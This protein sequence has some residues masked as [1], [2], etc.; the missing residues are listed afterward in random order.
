M[1]LFFK[2]INALLSGQLTEEDE[3]AVDEELAAILSEQ[4]PDVPTQEPDVSIEEDVEE[5]SP[6]KG[7][8][9]DICEIKYF[10]FFFF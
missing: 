8:N 4:I 5:P 1:F 3:A 10:I 2:E 6:E 7:I 9:I